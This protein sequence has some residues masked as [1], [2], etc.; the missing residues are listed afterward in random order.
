MKYILAHCGMLHGLLAILTNNPMTMM[1]DGEM[2]A[3]V[4]PDAAD[5]PVV[6]EAAPADAEAAPEAEEEAA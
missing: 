1:N 5:M 4:A 6:E 3:P 2:D